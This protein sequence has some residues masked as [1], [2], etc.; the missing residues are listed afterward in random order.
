[1]IKRLLDIGTCFAVVI[2]NP[3]FI[4]DSNYGSREYFILL[5][6]E[7]LPEDVQPDDDTDGL[8]QIDMSEDEVEH[9]KQISEEVFERVH[10]T[11]DGRVYELKNNSFKKYIK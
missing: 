11:E 6:S 8:V 4:A 3:K 2:S 1:M 5:R 9:F 10:H 7:D